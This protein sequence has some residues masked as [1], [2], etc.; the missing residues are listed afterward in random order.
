MRARNRW[1]PAL[2]ATALLAGL[3]PLLGGGH[4]VAS[5]APVSCTGN[6]KVFAVKG[7]ATLWLYE[8][9]TPSTG[10]FSWTNVRQIGSGWNGR[11]LVS[12]NG[13]VLHITANGTLQWF[14]YDGTRWANGGAPRTIGTGWGAYLNDERRIT[15]DAAGRIFTL[16]EFGRLRS[17]RFNEATWSWDD[18]A[19][20]VVDVYMSDY[21]RIRAAGDNV[22]YARHRN[23]GALH[24]FR[25]DAASARWTDCARPI[26]AGW[27]G[28]SQMFSPGGD[29]VYGVRHTQYNSGD[30][31]WFRYDADTGTWA[32]NGAGRLVGTGWGQFAYGFGGIGATTN[33]C[34]SPSQ[35]VGPTTPEGVRADHPLQVAGAS[36]FAYYY[37]GS[38]NRAFGGG[39]F[40]EQ[41]L[42]TQAFGSNLSAATSYGTKFVAGVDGSGNVW[43]NEG[44]EP[45]HPWVSL[46]GSMRAV[47]LTA[48]AGLGVVAIDAAGH[49]WSHP[50]YVLNDRGYWLGWRRVSGSSRFAE[51]FSVGGGGHQPY[52]VAR[53]LGESTATWF[54]ISGNSMRSGPV[55]AAAEFDLPVAGEVWARALVARHTATGQPHVLFG[56]EDGFE[57][58][59]SALPTLPAGTL[60]MSATEASPGL[61]AIAV[62]GSDGHVYV[63]SQ[64]PDSRRFHPWQRI[65]EATA[66]TGPMIASPSL[67]YVQLVFRGT[68]GLVH[69][70]GAQSPGRR[71]VPLAF[72]GGPIG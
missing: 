47:R 55:P 53:R 69:V 42:G 29:V 25:Y 43:I 21:D 18:P 5:A 6:A 30:L 31:L 71:D 59:W 39:S 16:D 33:T 72:T 60:P 7:D 37:V 24:R 32:N 14:R 49:L 4:P 28:I 46:R 27:N 56:T 13:T 48:Q 52:G 38:G 44:G 36:D 35:P 67:L 70:Y 66:A 15:V 68:D 45:G 17:Y 34:T 23:T 22:L 20:T 62:V 65:G 8:H 63:T 26:G 40:A 57:S 10:T 11:M 1:I 9:T 58:A 41:P 50:R 2:A 19:G 64:R 61:I 51:P 12:A 3:A 54:V